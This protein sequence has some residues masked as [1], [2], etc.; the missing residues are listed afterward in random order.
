[1]RSSEEFKIQAAKIGITRWPIHNCSICGYPCGYLFHD[2][3]VFYDSGCDCVN[4]ADIQPK[5]WEDVAQQYNMQTNEK[6]IA[7][8]DSFWG[9]SATKEESL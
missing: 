4:Y 2:D 7:E 1:M 8:M 3:Q 5:T 9:F 6:Y